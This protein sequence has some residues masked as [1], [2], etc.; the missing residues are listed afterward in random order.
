[1]DST[2]TVTPMSQRISLK[3]GETYSG[4]ITIVNPVDATSDF[5]YKVYVAPYGVTNEKYDADFVTSTDR[6][7]I[8]KW[9]TIKDAEG[10]IEPNGTKEVEF[11]IKVPESAPGGG[12]Y[13]SIMVG[14]NDDNESSEGIAVQN[15]FE[16]ASLIYAEVD[17]DIIHS[18]EI[19]EN[20]VPGFSAT[21]PVTVSSLIKND[22]NLHE[23][24]TFTISVSNFFT[25]EVILPTEENEGRYSEVIL[26]ET[27]KYTSREID[28]LPSIGIVHI[29]QTIN[30]N[31]TSSVKE[32]DVLICPIWFIALVAITLGVIIAVVVRIIMKHRKKK[33]V[34]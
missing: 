18:G 10:E 9:I 29:N 7:Q 24:A 5:K 17:G 4:S 32:K 28:N 3:P 14:S 21:T 2:F 8:A 20:N 12:Q 13:A 6:T 26:P 23:D 1:M 34:E 11:T 15:V 30:Y 33:K 22:G 31:G 25:G 19:L 27:T 16:M